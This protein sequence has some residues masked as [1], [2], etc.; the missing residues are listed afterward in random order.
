MLDRRAKLAA[1]AAVLSLAASLSTV[2]T[3]AQAGVEEQRLILL[4]GIEPREDH[5]F[6]KG[7]VLPSYEGRRAV[8]QRRVGRHGSWQDWKRFRTDDRSR[9]REPVAALRRIGRVYYRV[10]IGASGA[11]AESFSRAIFIRTYRL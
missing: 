8:I 5:F 4:R 3:P 11:F 9:Y 6:L 2:T 1:A 10:R 7:R